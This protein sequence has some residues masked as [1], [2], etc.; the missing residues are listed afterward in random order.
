[1]RVTGLIMAGG[2]GSRM[3][4]SGSEVPKPLV[5]VHGRTLLE[6]NVRAML[7][8]DVREVY[9][10]VN[11]HATQIIDFISSTCKPRVHAAGGELRLLVETQP[12]G[13]IGCLGMLNNEADAVVVAYA[14]NLTA[15][16]PQDLLCQHAERKPALTLAA[17]WQPF[18]MPFGEL[19]TDGDRVVGYLEK[20]TSQWLVSSAVCIAGPRALEAIPANT[21]TG[22]SQLTQRLIA[23]QAIV[24]TF[25]HSAPWIDVNDLRSAAKAEELVTNHLSRFAW[26]MSDRQL[27]RKAA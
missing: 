18:R 15:L 1:M 7:A 21:P 26:F 8:S 4:R 24:E 23:E 14:D 19:K 9:V 25:E 13:N 5:Q 6:H 3:S 20:P 17:H 16:K 27:Q 2:A 10:S 11:Q 22:L 12:L